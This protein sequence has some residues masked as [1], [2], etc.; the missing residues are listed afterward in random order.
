MI[1]YIVSDTAHKEKNQR[2]AR[3]HLKQTLEKEPMSWNKKNDNNCVAKHR[4]QSKNIMGCGSESSY[5]S[6]IS[7]SLRKL[8]F[9]TDEKFPNAMYTEKRALKI[10]RPKCRDRLKKGDDLI[11]MD[12]FL[13]PILKRSA[14][15]I[16]NLYFVICTARLN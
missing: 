7:R 6:F 10:S 9:K 13:M 2:L 3:R 1:A 4:K 15:G 14:T 11:T 8:R 12:Y 5:E 16:F